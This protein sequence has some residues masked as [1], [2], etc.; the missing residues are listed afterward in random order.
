MLSIRPVSDL[1]NYTDV[2][3]EVREELCFL[4]SGT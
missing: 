1:R 4:S 2:L 3:N